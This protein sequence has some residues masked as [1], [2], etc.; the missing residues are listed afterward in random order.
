MKDSN[1]EQTAVSQIKNWSLFMQCLNMYENN[2][3][4]DHFSKNTFAFKQFFCFLLL[5]V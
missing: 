2:E 4:C 3:V 5:C 1:V